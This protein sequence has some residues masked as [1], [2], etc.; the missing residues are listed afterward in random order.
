[1]AFVDRP[2]S[3]TSMDDACLFVD[4]TKDSQLV[5]KEGNLARMLVDYYLL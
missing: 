5:P 2:P 1:M 4:S 3:G